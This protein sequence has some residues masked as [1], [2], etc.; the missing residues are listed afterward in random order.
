MKVSIY[1]V[2]SALL[3]I[4]IINGC[5]SPQGTADAN[6][7]SRI[8]S[9]SYSLGFFYGQSL[10]AEGVDSLQNGQFIAGLNQ[11]IEGEESAIDQMAAQALMQSFQQELAASQQARQQE[12][13]SEN[14][15]EGEEFLEENAQKDDVMVTESGLQ[16]RVIEEGSGE[17]P[18]AE[19]TVTVHYVG[20]LIDGT[21]F[22]T[23]RKEVA[24]ENDLYSAQ[25]EP[26]EGA[27]FPVNRV[28]SGWT[29][30]LQLM[31]EGATYEFFIPSD[32]AYGNNPPPGSVI[33]PG[34]ALIFEVELIEVN[35]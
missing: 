5:E 29:E 14:I 23:S 7:E 13:A 22:D 4:L 6:L 2:L 25:R 35:E 9:V 19:N 26:Y 8:D 28:I 27:T 17:S 21:V 30:G 24:Q 16:Y 33:E 31:S 34:S 15:A 1:S 18:T 32:L 10:A 3:F 20:T 12:A 11:A